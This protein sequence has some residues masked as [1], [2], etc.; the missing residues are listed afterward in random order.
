MQSR[1]AATAAKFNRVLL[2]GGQKRLLPQRL[3]CATSTGRTADPAVHS[4]EPEE[5]DA[6][7]GIMD[8]KRRHLPETESTTKDNESYVPPKSPLESS[9]KLESPGVGP[10]TDPLE[11]QKRRKSAKAAAIDNVSCAEIDISPWP[12]DERETKRKEQSEE[13]I[14]DDREYFKHHKA[15]PLSEIEFADT[16]KPITKATDDT[17][18]N[19]AFGYA[20]GG[21][22]LWRPE[23]LDTAEDS[24][25]R[26]AEIFRE[27]AIRGDP[28]S[29]HGRVLRQLRGEY[30]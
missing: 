16:R 29:S 20:T 4:V 21:V 8:E 15:S 5:V 24:L 25:H 27:N 30:W 23:Q 7:A 12:D 13:Q 1:L 28:D 14:E 22:I 6:N 18:Q 11:Q 17:A 2:S 10:R 3:G 19:D 9:P 26:A